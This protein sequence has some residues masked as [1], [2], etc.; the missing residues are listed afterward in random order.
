MLAAGQMFSTRLSPHQ[1]RRT[2]D[3]DEMQGTGVLPC[4]CF[5]GEWLFVRMD[6]FGAGREKQSQ[7]YVMFCCLGRTRIGGRAE[8]S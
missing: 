2:S 3:Q 6:S 4:R 7:P 1:F 8:P 5:G